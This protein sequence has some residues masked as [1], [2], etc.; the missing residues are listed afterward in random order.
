MVAKIKGKMARTTQAN[1][2]LISRRKNLYGFTNNKMFPYLHAVFK[3]TVSM[4]GALRA[5]RDNE[6]NGQSFKDKIFE[7][8]IPPFLRFIHKNNIQPAGW[9]KIT[10]GNYKVNLGQER[11]YKVPD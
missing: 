8:N 4:N 9:I 6:I 11:T 10:P 1:L 5:L 2:Y 7:S 3:D